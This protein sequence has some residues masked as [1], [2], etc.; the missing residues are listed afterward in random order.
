MLRRMP[1][2]IELPF[3]APPV[4]SARETPHAIALGDRIVPYLLRRS[5]RRSIGLSIDEHGL[6]VGAPVR[7]TLGEIENLI[8]RHG[9]WVAQKLDEWRDRR[10]PPPR[11]IVDGSEIAYLGR[12][13]RLHLT[14]GGNQ[15]R[16]E[17]EHPEQ[18]TDGL[19]EAPPRLTLALR[20]PAEAERLLER[21]LRTR[22]LALF[23]VRL[24]HFAERFGL[25]P[26]PLALSS[27]RTRWGSC[28]LRTGIRLNWRLIHHRLALIDYIVIHE[29]AHLREMNHSARFWALVER[30]CPDYRQLRDELKQISTRAP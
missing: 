25:M 5:R 16:W 10:R 15:I 3:P 23:K 30:H 26:P 11:V 4:R 1:R 18:P 6:R 21:A 14:Q 24:A 28:S 17:H 7:A 27:A 13:L 22:A 19:D 20:T 12:T 9:D 8:R 29:L 2:Q